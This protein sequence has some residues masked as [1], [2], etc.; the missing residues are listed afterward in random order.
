MADPLIIER[1]GRVV[2]LINNAPPY[3]P[4]NFDFM[5][6]LEEQVDALDIDATVGAVVLRSAGD[7][8]FSVG[9]NLKETEED[10][11]RKGG[12]EAV[13]DQALRIITKIENM[14]KPW[15]ATLYGYCLGGGLEFPLGCHFRLAAENGAKIGLP[16]F[17]I[18]S[19]P[20]LGGTARLTRCVGQANALD[21]I[22][23]VKMISGPEAYRIG[24]VQ[25]VYPNNELQQRA[26]D[27]AQELA[28]R[29]PKAMASVLRCVVGAQ[30][31][32]VS[33]VIRIERLEVRRSLG[34]DEL[35]E[36]MRAFAEKRTPNYFPDES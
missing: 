34:G 19:L 8:H 10:I 33:E 35:Q 30:N 16:E 27:L 17:D 36:G 1:N 9:M 3:N 11:A 32:A 13:L 23:R 31:T 26:Q 14:D 21:M 4:I 15:I 29:P 6:A 20:A 18:G 7:D 22:L 24:L 5:D 25:Y 12:T 28:V 2:T